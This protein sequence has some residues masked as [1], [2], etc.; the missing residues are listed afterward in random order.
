M[1]L[2]FFIGFFSIQPG[3]NNYDSSGYTPLMLSVIDKDYNKT[4]ELL[5]KG[6][7]PDI[8]RNTEK[9]YYKINQETLK[10]P[11]MYA[12]TLGDFKTVKLLIKYG[13]DV[14][15]RDKEDDTP[16]HYAAYYVR[17]EIAKILVDNG[18]L[19]NAKDIYGFT[20]LDYAKY[21]L[22]KDVVKL[23]QENN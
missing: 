16:L 11:L 23:L 19:L 3:I 17:P 4:E 6:A 21:K 12:A 18:A 14:N 13:A 2:L 5:K 7:N 9:I 22:A 10:T 20:P 15:V 8:G 1:F